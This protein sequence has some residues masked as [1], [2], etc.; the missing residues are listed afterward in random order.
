[1]LN[2][3]TQILFDKEFWNKLNAFA[4]AQN[5]SVGELIRSAVKKEYGEQ[6]LKAGRGK[7]IEKIVAFRKK[8]GGKFD[9]GEDSVTLI[10]SMRKERTKHLLSL[11]N[12]KV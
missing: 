9:T 1:M 12:L 8:Y 11:I 4:N 10:R 5:T 6:L 2:K 7:A 3:R